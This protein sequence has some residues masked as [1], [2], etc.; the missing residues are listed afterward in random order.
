MLKMGEGGMNKRLR[1]GRVGRMWEEVG[2]ERCG[3][4]YRRGVCSVIGREGEK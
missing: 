4:C 1:D 2:R 3:L